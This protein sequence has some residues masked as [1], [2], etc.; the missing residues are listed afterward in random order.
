MEFIGINILP[1]SAI[2]Y[3]KVYFIALLQCNKV[4]FNVLY[5]TAYPPKCN[6]VNFNVHTRHF[7]TIENE[8]NKLNLI[9]YRFG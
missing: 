4:D 2:K 1:H 8:K 7:Q 9:C 6:E 5:C 3:I